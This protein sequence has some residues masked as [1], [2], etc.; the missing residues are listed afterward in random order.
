MDEC[1]DAFVEVVDRDV[2]DHCDQVFQQLVLLEDR[3]ALHK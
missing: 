3:S 1:V 2:F